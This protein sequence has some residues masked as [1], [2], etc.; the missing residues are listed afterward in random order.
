MQKRQD[1]FCTER[2]YHTNQ[3]EVLQGILKHMKDKLVDLV[4]MNF[5]NVV[6]N[7]DHLRASKFSYGKRKNPQINI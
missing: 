5:E 1:I 7:F 3:L 2:L 4:Y 6:Y